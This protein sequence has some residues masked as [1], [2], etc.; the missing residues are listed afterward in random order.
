MG[1]R[2]GERGVHNGLDLSSAPDTIER[3]YGVQCWDTVPSGIDEMTP[4]PGLARALAA[5]DRTRISG[6]DRV[7]VLR[8]RQRLLSHV[9]AELY[10]DMAAVVDSYMEEVGGPDDVMLYAE[11]AQGAAAEIRGA[12]RWTRRAA[13]NEVGIAL[14]LRDR[15][16]RVLDALGDGEI[17]RPRA[18]TFV[19]QTDHLR[20]ETV[21]KVVAALIDR[22]AELTTGQLVGELRRL[23][24]SVDPE[25]A[26]RRYSQALEERRIVAEANPEGTANLLLLDIDPA[27]ASAVGQR[28]DHIAKS[29]RGKGETRTMD[30]LR[31]DVATDLLL[32]NGPKS[33]RGVVDIKVDLTTLAGLAHHPGELGG[34]G[35]VVAEIARQTA[36]RQRDA[37]WRFTVVDHGVSIGGGIIRRRPTA[38]QRRAVEARDPV[39]VFPGCRMPATQCEI[40]H[41]TPYSQQGPT[42]A[43]NLAPPC[44]HDHH[45]RHRFGWSYH[46]IG[47]GDYVWRSPL[48]HAYTTSGRDP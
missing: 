1:T 25:E 22:A 13:D 7:T 14:E 23:A 35:P 48:G 8:V 10:R 21:D 20:R 27:K 3:M 46:P 32:G 12:L 5:V 31:T 15:L 47:L 4:G 44:S 2:G 29:L 11:A 17:D 24:M 39:C 40:D 26:T 42:D 33:G 43:E 45:I 6:Y 18:R 30:Q 16:P 41:R 19:H 36:D 34:Y 37:S 38:G 9:Q 28:L